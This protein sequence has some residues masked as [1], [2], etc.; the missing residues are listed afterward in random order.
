MT[1]AVWT[2]K[3][4]NISSSLADRKAIGEELLKFPDGVTYC[5]HFIA[6][7]SD[8]E[9]VTKSAYALDQAVR[10]NPDILQPHKT[11]FF[12]ALRTLEVDTVKR[13]FA[14]TLELISFDFLKGSFPLQK[15][16]QELMVSTC[17]DWLIADEKVAVK[18]F[19]MQCLYNLKDTQTWI[20]GELKA[21]L[22]SQFQNASPA[23]Q[24]RAR[25]ILKKLKN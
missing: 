6:E 2:T 16:E 8:N 17:F 14:K 24:S 10:S 3:I 21:Q 12:K 4:L 20:E 9:L 25:H 19:A 18:A 22:N 13:I 15:P 5:L 11:L 1:E 23:F 7:S